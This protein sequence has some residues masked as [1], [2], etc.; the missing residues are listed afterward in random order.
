MIKLFRNIRQ[1]LAAEN[2]FMAYSRYAIGEIVL[3]VIGILIALSIN[4]WNSQKKLRGEE[5]NM[6]NEIKL[7]LKTC[8]EELQYTLKSNKQFENNYILL[9]EHIEGKRPYKPELD[10]I[11][12]QV[13]AWQSP[14]LTYSAYE[15][16]KSKG[17]DIIQNDS[18]R[19]QIINIYESA[20][21]YLSKDWDQSEWR[22]SQSVVVP[23]FVKHFAR[24]IDSLKAKPIDYDALI[25]DP[26][27]ANIL[28]KLITNRKWGNN[29]C[30]GISNYLDTVVANIDKELETR[31][32][33]SDTQ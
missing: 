19:I 17:A 3:V 30:E 18:L 28:R 13:H 21:T 6:L 15:T 31:G 32:F 1:K 10:T 27:F 4:N 26:E 12:S 8:K 29:A 2:K 23:Y 5:L 22:D 20:F 25:A 33:K 9:L 7:N 16:L 11:F 14:Y 24:D